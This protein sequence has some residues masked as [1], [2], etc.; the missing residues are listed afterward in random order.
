MEN[1]FS[2]KHQSTFPGWEAWKD[3]CK[4]GIECRV[5]IEKKGNKVI[6]YTENQGILLE[7]T[8]SVKNA[9]P[10]DKIYVALTGDQCAITDI[11][12]RNY[13]K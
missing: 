12:V 1:R 6:I 2:M 11:R 9:S 13:E 3:R 4:E 8:M 10:T 5:E 7:D